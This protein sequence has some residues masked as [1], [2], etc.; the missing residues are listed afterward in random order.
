MIS[1]EK[2][3]TLLI[4]LMVCLGWAWF[5][6]IMIVSQCH[7]M[8]STTTSPVPK[9]HNIFTTDPNNN[10]ISS[11]D[12]DDTPNLIQ[13]VQQQYGLFSRPFYS[14]D[15]DDTFLGCVRYSSSNHNTRDSKFRTGQAFGIIT[16]LL[17][18][19]SVIVSASIALIGFNR[20]FTAT[21]TT[22]TDSRCISSRSYWWW[23]I[24]KYCST[25]AA[26]TQLL[27]L[28][29]I[30]SSVL[31]YSN[32]TDDGDDDD[33]AYS[34][35]SG[36]TISRNAKLAIFNTILLNGIAVLWFFVAIPDTPF[37]QIRQ[38]ASSSSTEDDNHDTNDSH[39]HI[40]SPHG[41]ISDTS[42]EERF[43]RY[44]SKNDPMKIMQYDG[45]N[46][47]DDTESIISEYTTTAE[48]KIVETPTLPHH[49]T[50]HN[51][52]EIPPTSIMQILK[53]Y[54]MEHLYHS[55]LTTVLLIG[56]VWMVSIFGV[57]RCTL[58]YATEVVTNEDDY[59]DD[60]S[61]NEMTYRSGIGLY[62]MA[63][64]DHE[65]LHFLGCVAYP[66]QTIHDGPF[67]TAR[68]FGVITTLVTSS[69]FLLSILQL[70]VTRYIP[71]I[72]LALK[73]LL[74]L[75]IVTEATTF[76]I[77]RSDVCKIDGVVSCQLGGT[78]KLV[79]LNILLLA[80]I[81]VL[82]SIRPVPKDPL[83]EMVSKKVNMGNLK[84]F[85]S[86]ASPKLMIDAWSN[87]R[88]S[89]RKL[90]YQSGDIHVTD[91]DPQ[92]TADS[93]GTI[94]TQNVND[95]ASDDCDDNVTS[96]V[97]QVEYNSETEK[98]TRKIITYQD[99]T[100]TIHTTIEEMYDDDDDDDC[101]VSAVLEPNDD[102]EYLE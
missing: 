87:L 89:D 25:V 67:R 2:D 88:G 41:T 36:C 14:D 59:Y 12:D 26:V 81:Y 55:Q 71:Q 56:I 24:A 92:S 82:V 76:A 46:E 98:T 69:M 95:V 6:S 51:S 84:S 40:P 102:I 101:D 50:K 9:Y 38:H 63:I 97:I 23:H 3:S 44:H 29:A 58:V 37:I 28:I 65:R 57:N 43:D 35:M 5:D 20:R 99:G 22:E 21:T 11:N 90:F 94:H 16:V 77:F 72:S 19:M 78:G 79:I 13:T 86:R 53:R 75:A 83:L 15:D 52:C 70:F 60:D 30:G 66:S 1:I 54:T 47:M 33:N 96:I 64:H 93:S 18:T 42:K 10:N 62:Q 61:N 91:D 27:T 49:D 74:P 100:Q 7:F 48:C 39:H 80:A 34:S 17:L 45:T 32:H 8:T 4:L 31:C 68:A 85:V 73:I